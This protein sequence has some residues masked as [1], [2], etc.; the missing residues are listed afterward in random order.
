MAATV[1]TIT[2]IGSLNADLITRTERIPDGGETL[3]AQSF[4]TGAGG[5]GANQAVACARLSRARKDV[6]EFKQSAKTSLKSGTAASG[7]NPDLGY[8]RVSMV[9]VVGDDEFGNMLIETLKA[10]MIDVS[11]VTKTL[12]AKTGVAVIIVEEGTGENRIMLNS[13]ANYT[14]EPRA[15]RT[16]EAP[17]PA[18]IVLQLEI[19]LETV[20]QILETAWAKHVPV[21]LNAAP[22]TAL[23][24]MTYEKITHLIVNENEAALISGKSSQKVVS[25]EECREIASSFLQKGIRNVVITL[26]GDGVYFASKEGNRPEGSLPAAKATVVDTTAAGDTFVGAYAVEAALT[27]RGQA[28]DIRNAVDKGNRAAAKTVEKEGAQSSIPYLDEISDTEQVR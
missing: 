4:D 13:G 1:P 10:E 22:A 9:G 21:L 7:S 24:E 6:I 28:F 16:L 5:K 25:T 27:K 2:V 14:L 23:P 19:P 26:G 11:R 15:F 8:V 20:M 18:L 3:T 17:L 12:A